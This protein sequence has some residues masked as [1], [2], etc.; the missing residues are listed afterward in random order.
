MR[1]L[2]AVMAV[3]LVLGTA[4]CVTQ[5]GRTSAAGPLTLD[6]VVL[7][8]AER[9]R[10][11][12]PYHVIVYTLDRSAAYLVEF[13]QP[14]APLAESPEHIEPAAG[15]AGRLCARRQDALLVNGQRC[16]ISAILRYKIS[17]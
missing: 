6:C 2:K 14:C 17:G 9:W 12:D 15:E 8:A 4:G 5:R 16:E 7:P 1:F 11:L 3:V 13:S 10:V